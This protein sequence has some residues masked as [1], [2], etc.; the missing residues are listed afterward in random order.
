MKEQVTGI[1]FD[2]F[3]D[4]YWE[5]ISDLEN[6]NEELAEN[7][8]EQ[9]RKSIIRAMM[10]DKYKK[11]VR[12]LYKTWAEY[13]E[14]GYTKDEVDALREMQEQL[15]EAVLAERD[16]LADIFGWDASGDS[17]SQS[18]S[19][20]Y[21]TTMSQETGEEIS[22][23]LTA[24]YESNVRLETKGTEM[25]ANMLIIS[26]AALNM[27]KELAA[28]LVCVT[29]MRDVLHECNDHLEKIEKYTGILSGMD[30]TLAEIEKNTKGM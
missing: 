12:K 13:G 6:G 11:Q 2:S 10:A 28:H 5:M 1:S 24:M 23:R 18:S 26:T 15:S 14:D 19:K 25:N 27:A 7:L 20:G 4:S 8:E 9:L 3:E 17:Y 29:E 21:S 30:D 22:G 16:S